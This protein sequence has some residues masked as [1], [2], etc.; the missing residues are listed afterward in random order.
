MSEDPE[1]RWRRL[2]QALRDSEAVYH[3]LVEQLPMNVFRKDREGRFLFVNALLCRTLG[4]RREEVLGKSARRDS[5]WT[6][7]TS[8]G[9]KRRW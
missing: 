2:E 8:S 3:S 5:S 1:Q 4:R 9:P 7:P 6:S